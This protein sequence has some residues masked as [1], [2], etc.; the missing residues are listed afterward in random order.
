MNFDIRDI[1]LTIVGAICFALM[2]VVLS[3]CQTA[4][5]VTVTEYR[6]SIRTEYKTDSIM[7]YAKDSIFI[8]EKGD[9]VFVDKYHLIYRDRVKTD[10]VYQQTQHEIPVVTEVEVQK[11]YI[12]KWV[13][14]LLGFNIVLAMAG[15]VKLYLKIKPV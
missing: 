13:W 15:A 12:P 6:D 7:V 2:L 11:R 5:V 8:R 3:S 4:K 9:T 10:T 14:W 1:L